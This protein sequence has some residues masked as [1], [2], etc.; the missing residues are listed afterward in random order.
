MGNRSEGMDDSVDL[1]ERVRKWIELCERGQVVFREHLRREAESDGFRIL[2]PGVVSKT[3][4]D[5]GMK[6]MANPASLLEAQAA[7]WR[8]SAALWQAALE[9][10][11]GE[12]AQPIIETEKSDRRFKDESWEQEVFLVLRRFRWN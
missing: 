8:D 3:F 4:F 6:A 2:D 9:G 10:R 5:W 12:G 11:I 7:L 1:A